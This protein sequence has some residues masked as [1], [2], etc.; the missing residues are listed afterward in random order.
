QGVLPLAFATMALSILMKESAKDFFSAEA[1]V[2]P[3]LAPAGNLNLLGTAISWQNI[4]VI[5]VAF[6]AIALLQWFVTR[7][8]T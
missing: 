8:R 6:T 5:A 7:T 4:L 1:Q 2:F 3:S